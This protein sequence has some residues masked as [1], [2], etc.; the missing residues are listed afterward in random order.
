ML[1][2]SPSR[3]QLALT[4][5]STLPARQKFKERGET[6]KLPILGGR[7]GA[8]AFVEGGRCGLRLKLFKKKDCGKAR[9]EQEQMLSCQFFLSVW[10]VPPIQLRIVC[11]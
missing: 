10:A 8:G 1:P 3:T 11:V 4:R 5:N 7:A 9:K 6:F 2:P